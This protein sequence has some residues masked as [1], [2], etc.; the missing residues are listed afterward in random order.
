MAPSSA[1]FVRT[2]VASQLQMGLSYISAED[3]VVGREP[4]DNRVD[5]NPRIFKSNKRLSVL[6]G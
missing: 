2:V 3:K 6:V 4:G 5:C 1:L